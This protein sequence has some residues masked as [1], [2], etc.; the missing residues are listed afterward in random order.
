MPSKKRERVLTGQR[1]DMLVVG[2]TI[3]F[4]LAYMSTLTKWKI[5]DEVINQY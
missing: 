2:S 4:E 5:V 1:N 3:I